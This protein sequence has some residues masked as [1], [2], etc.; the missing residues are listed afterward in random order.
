VSASHELGRL[1]REMPE[2]EKAEYR[3]VAAEDLERYRK[4]TA[5]TA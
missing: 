4:E 1:W 2:S 3:R 5:K